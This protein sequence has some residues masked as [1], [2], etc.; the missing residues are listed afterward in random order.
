ML[1]AALASQL[2]YYSELLKGDAG[3]QESHTFS[4]RLVTKVKEAASATHGHCTRS[5]AEKLI[6]TWGADIQARWVEDNLHL[7]ITMDMNKL[8][9]SQVCSSNLANV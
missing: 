4:H 3:V 7:S 2:M 5:Q 8:R 1:H 6:Q 9:D